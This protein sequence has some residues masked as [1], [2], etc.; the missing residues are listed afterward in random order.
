[1]FKAGSKISSQYFYVVFK[2]NQIGYPRFAFVASKK[3]FRK[4]T[5]RNRVKRL[6]REVARLLLPKLNLLSCDI[7]FVGKLEI[8]NLKSYQLKENL[9]GILEKLEKECLANS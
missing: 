9:E 5:Q 2:K 7:I 4:S 6:L 3:V 8:L 1:M